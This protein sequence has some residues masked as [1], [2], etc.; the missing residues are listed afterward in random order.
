MKRKTA[1]GVNNLDL[2]AKVPS[3]PCKTHTHSRLEDTPHGKVKVQT[4]H[5][6]RAGGEHGA[7][8]S[9]AKNGR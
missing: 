3:T 8:R 5:S 7:C 9:E 1:T 6:R 4:V 2:L